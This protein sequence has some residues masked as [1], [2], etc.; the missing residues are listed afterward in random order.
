[1][2]KRQ[3]ASSAASNGRNRQVARPQVQAKR[4]HGFSVFSHRVELGIEDETALIG[5][6]RAQSFAERSV[7][8][9]AVDLKW[10]ADLT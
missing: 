5:I 7:V 2:V 8:V 3:N 1:V 6:G 9:L 4:C 10:L